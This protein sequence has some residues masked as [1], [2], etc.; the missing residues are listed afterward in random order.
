MRPI[1]GTHANPI[2]STGRLPSADQKPLLVLD[3]NSNLFDGGLSLPRIL[4]LTL[5]HVRHMGVV[6]AMKQR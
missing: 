6:T 1:L 2:A 4:T 3:P 5:G